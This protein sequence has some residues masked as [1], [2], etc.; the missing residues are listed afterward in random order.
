MI[1]DTILD[2]R[3]LKGKKT[4]L[5]LLMDGRMDDGRKMMKKAYIAFKAR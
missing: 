3:G 5:Q 4:F 2:K 1:P